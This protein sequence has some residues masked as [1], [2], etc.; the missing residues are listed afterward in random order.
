M[1]TTRNDVKGDRKGTLDNINDLK[2]NKL[3]TNEL[4]TLII[5]VTGGCGSSCSKLKMSGNG[6]VREQ[7]FWE[8]KGNGMSSKI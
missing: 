1:V 6:T 8:F 5:F 7:S 4:R 2:S 3:D